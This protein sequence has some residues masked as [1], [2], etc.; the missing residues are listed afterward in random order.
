MVPHLHDMTNYM[1]ICIIWQLLHDIT[2]IAKFCIFLLKCQKCIICCYSNIAQRTMFLKIGPILLLNVSANILL[3][4]TSSFICCAIAGPQQQAYF[5]C[6]YKYNQQT[7]FTVSFLEVKRRFQTILPHFAH[8]M[9]TAQ[10]C[11]VCCFQL[12]NLKFHNFKKKTQFFRPHSFVFECTTCSLA[13]EVFSP[14]EQ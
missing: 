8:K 10:F 11:I 2:S 3:H 14:L 4:I 6:A 9:Q 5:A 1:I 13:V 12:H 7:Q